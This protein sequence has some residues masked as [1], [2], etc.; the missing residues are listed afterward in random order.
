MI[1]TSISKRII[2]TGG[3]FQKPELWTTLLYIRLGSKYDS[4]II[5][6]LGLEGNLKPIQFQSP[7]MGQ[8]ATH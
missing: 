5:E 6:W 7:A 2:D 4:R 1:Y 8:V 3:G